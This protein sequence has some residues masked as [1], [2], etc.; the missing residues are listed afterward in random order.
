MGLSLTVGSLW[1][2]GAAPSGL[3]LR[4]RPPPCR[5]IPFSVIYFPLFANLNSL[6]VSEPVGKASFAHSFV[7]GC[8]AGSVAAV[9]VTPLD[10]ECLGV[11]RASGS[12]CLTS[13][14]P[15]WS[16]TG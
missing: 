8:V 6:G 7:S 1:P 15:V 16:F 4:P 10:G 9:A 3:W 13:G 2:Q 14:A 5:D 11:G 12:T